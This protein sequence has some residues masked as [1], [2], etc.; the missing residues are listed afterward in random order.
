MSGFNSLAELSIELARKGEFKKAQDVANEA[1]N[2]YP[3]NPALVFSLISIF[4]NTKAG[5]GVVHELNELIS[6]MLGGMGKARGVK[7]LYPLVNCLRSKMIQAAV[8]SDSF[9]S[10]I[11]FPANRS[12]V[13]SGK[14]INR[15]GVV[16]CLWKRWA[17]SDV[18]LFHL[19]QLKRELFGEIDLVPLLA[20]SEGSR[21]RSLCNKYSF[22]YFEL[23]NYPI[24]HKWEQC[25]ARARDFD[26]DAV[27]ILGSDD[28][29]NANLIRAYGRLLSQSVQCAGLRNA[30]FCDLN[31]DPARLILWHG[32]GSSAHCMGQPHRLGETIGMARFFSRDLLEEL[33][34]SLWP[35]LSINKGL[36]Y[37]ALKRVVSLGHLPVD[38]NCFKSSRRVGNCTKPKGQV[39]LDMSEL[40]GFAVDVKY[41]GHNITSFE[42]YMACQCTHSEIRDPW[43]ALELG[44]GKSTAMRL[45]WLFAM[46]R[47]SWSASPIAM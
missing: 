7:D 38:L 22:N 35:G 40:M 10:S 20:G 44:L 19:H 24:S 25:L 30:Y 36:D 42:K 13:G 1:I 33:G 5:R 31:Q 9:P 21:T 32:Y 17:L 39:C 26:L 34:Y 8:S 37:F 2:L 29:V 43:E 3:A 45:R 46:S 18:F 16:S 14:R 23:D 12:V 27:I 15:I 11:R 6:T 41:G 47:R 28:F 4:G